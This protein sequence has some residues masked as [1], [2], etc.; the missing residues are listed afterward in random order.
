M[1]F[2]CVIGRTSSEQ[3]LSFGEVK[4]HTQIINC[5]AGGSLKGQL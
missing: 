1:C 2:V 3:L 5:K 4:H